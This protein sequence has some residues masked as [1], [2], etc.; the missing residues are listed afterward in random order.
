MLRR[1]LQHAIE[2]TDW[3]FVTVCAVVLLVIL[4]VNVAA[5]VAVEKLAERP[6]IRKG[7]LK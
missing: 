4:T 5:F 2:K 6:E 1:W 7:L 3:A